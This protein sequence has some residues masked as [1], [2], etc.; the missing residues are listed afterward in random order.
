[1]VAKCVLVR[2]EDKRGKLK[3][4]GTLKAPEM[5]TAS[6]IIRGEPHDTSWFTHSF[7]LSSYSICNNIFIVVIRTLPIPTDY[8]YRF[9]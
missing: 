2:D 6:R 5:G 8:Y 3:N 1:M 4:R 9:I 7:P